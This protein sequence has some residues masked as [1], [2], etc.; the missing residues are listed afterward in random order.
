MKNNLK[1]N[2]NENNDQI[3]GVVVEDTNTT[4]LVDQSGAGKPVKPL[5]SKDLYAMSTERQE[6]VLAFSEQIDLSKAD[7]VMNYG[8]ATLKQISS[9]CSQFIQ[10]CKGSDEEKRVKQQLNEALGGVM[11]I[12]EQKP[13]FFKNL[14]ASATEKYEELKERYQSLDAMIQKLEETL[15]KQDE[16]MAENVKAEDAYGIANIQA[17]QV[18]EEYIVAGYLALEKAEQEKLPEL[19][20]QAETG[21]LYSTELTDYTRNI[22]QFQRKLLNLETQR[23]QTIGTLGLTALAKETTMNNRMRISD[24]ISCNMTALRQFCYVAL[25]NARNELS[26]ELTDDIKKATETLARDLSAQ[27]CKNALDVAKS[28]SKG[29]MDPA[30]LKELATSVLQTAQQMDQIYSDVGK[31]TKDSIAQIRG[32]EEDLQ[33]MLNGTNRVNS[34]K[35][36]SSTTAGDV[37]AA[38]TPKVDFGGLHL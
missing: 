32:V 21:A 4:A 30:C 13:S 20:L 6:R 26:M 3:Q 10:S 2:G 1:K 35:L 5:G 33:A 14:F 7:V 23:A 37:Q 31:L 29:F 34:A 18:L 22:A 38:S 19:Q 12:K 27:V 8:T 9:G 25:L 24:T 11:K 36:P 15:A 16:L 17:V 28:S